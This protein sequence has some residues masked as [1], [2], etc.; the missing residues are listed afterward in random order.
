MGLGVELHIN[1]RLIESAAAVH[2]TGYMKPR[3]RI[4]ISR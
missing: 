4:G 3:L 1:E 2:F